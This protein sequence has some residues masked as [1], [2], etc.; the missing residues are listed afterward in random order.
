MKKIFVYLPFVLGA[1]LF[2]SSCEKQNSKMPTVVSTAASVE[3]NSKG[4]L[5]SPVYYHLMVDPVTGNS[6]LFKTSGS[7]STPPVIPSAFP[8]ACG[9]NVIRETS[10][11]A[12][13]P[14]TYVTGIASDPGGTVIWATTGPA[15]NYPNSLLK[16]PIT[17]V[18][19]AAIIPLIPSCGIVLNVSDIEYN[20]V[21]NRYY[22]INRGNAV[23]NNRIVE[24][25]TAPGVNVICLAA[26][27]PVNRQLRG[28]TFGCNGQ[29]YVMQVNG[30]NGK[31]WSFSP[32]TGATGLPA[33]PY[34]I[35][36]PGAAAGTFPEM[37][38]H[39]DCSSCLNKFITGNYQPIAGIP[40][41]TDGM[42]ACIGPA[43]YN[44]LSGVIKPTVDFARP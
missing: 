24:I 20:K 17:N 19:N 26:T 16:I 12:C 1:L 13:S 25:L 23:V 43:S 36:A 8:G 31:I 9:D 34:G 29:G 5:C 10:S 2:W 15:S 3:K 42:P 33:C 30:P 28:L 7:P 11:G 38:L 6:Y 18:N 40:L 4:V 39:F 21:N 37:G 44:S 32:A 14:I 35:V 27:V 22:A 41:L